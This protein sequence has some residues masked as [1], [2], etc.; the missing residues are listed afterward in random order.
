MTACKFMKFERQ[1]KSVDAAAMMPGLID[2]SFFV[3]VLFRLGIDV[4]ATFRMDKSTGA[5]SLSSASWSSYDHLSKSSGAL[6]LNTD[7]F[8]VEHSSVHSR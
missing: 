4:A 7:G 8:A 5:L 1:F 6:F 2:D 3:V